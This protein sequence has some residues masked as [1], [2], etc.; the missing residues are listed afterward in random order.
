VRP[1]HYQRHERFRRYTRRTHD[2][3]RPS[4]T[5]ENPY[6]SRRNRAQRRCQRTSYGRTGRHR[7][8]CRPAGTNGQMLNPEPGLARCGSRGQAEEAADRLLR[9]PASSWQRRIQAFRIRQCRKP[10]VLGDEEVAGSNRS[11]RQRGVSGRRCILNCYAER[12]QADRLPLHTTCAGRRFAI[13][14]IP[15]AAPRRGRRQISK[16]HCVKPICA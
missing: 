6:L 3:R 13:D 2:A 8:I 7:S 10:T 5:R 15:G 14:A 9:Q 16:L 1:P 4:R 12:A 11:P